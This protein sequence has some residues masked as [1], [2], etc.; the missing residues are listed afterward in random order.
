MVSVKAEAHVMALH[1]TRKFVMATPTS[2]AHNRHAQT[3]K[4]LMY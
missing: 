3:T 4:I 1:T 2:V